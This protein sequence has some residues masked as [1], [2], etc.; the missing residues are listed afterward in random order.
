[1]QLEIY[2]SD[3]LYRY[4][5]VTIPELGSFITQRVSA[6]VHESTHAFYPPK[7]VLSFNEQIQSNDG[8]LARYIADVEKI[9]F[10]VAVAKIE[11]SVKKLKAYFTQGETITFNNIGD[12]SFNEEG[13]ILFEPSYHL[14]YLTD[15]FGLSQFVSPA[16]TREAFK[17]EATSIE[18]VIPIA[19]TPEKRT[20]NAVK[21]N[22]IKYAAIAILALTVGG[23]ASSKFYVNKMESQNQIAQQEANAQLENQIQEATFVINNP[24][25]A[26]ILNVNKQIGNYHI[27]AGAF[28]VE[29]NSNKKV[30]QLKEQGFDAK[31]IGSNAYGL[32]Q[33][34]YASYTDRVEALQA[35]KSIKQ[36]N[37]KDA[38]LLVKDLN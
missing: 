21:R 33:V 1:M 11:K 20:S 4:D 10:A 34:A 28:R 14:N 3:L 13:K 12:L 31:K 22:Y 23:L 8:L 9:P 30:Q 5:C 16:V 15:A 18:K 19:V 32:H 7:K 35:L 26:V 29:E 2:I 17:T 37:N 27:V 6:K 24:L 36:S 25:P 38:W